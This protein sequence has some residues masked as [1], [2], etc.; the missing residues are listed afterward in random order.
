MHVTFRGLRVIKKFNIG[1][2]NLCYWLCMLMVC[3]FVVSN[4]TV[5]LNPLTP[6]IS[7]VILLTVCHTV[8]VML[9]WR[10]WYG[11]SL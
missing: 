4:G 6:K 3:F 9:V 7:I 1:T 11:I 5:T 8:L 2:I 10:I